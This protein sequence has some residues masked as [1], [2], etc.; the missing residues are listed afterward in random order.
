MK[1]SMKLKDLFWNTKHK[2]QIKKLPYEHKM[3]KESDEM[4]FSN[5]AVVINLREF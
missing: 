1:C 3:H 2:I 5:F 4:N